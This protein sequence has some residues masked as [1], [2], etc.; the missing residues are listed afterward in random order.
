MADV[1]DLQVSEEIEMDDEEGDREYCFI[2]QIIYKILIQ[3]NI[4]KLC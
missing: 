1:L 2:L 3:I 4:M